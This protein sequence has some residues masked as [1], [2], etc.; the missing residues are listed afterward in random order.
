VR[1]NFRERGPERIRGY[2]GNAGKEA[3]LT[4]DRLPVFHGIFIIG[5]LKGFPQVAYTR[6][7]QT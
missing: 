2:G 6:K 4:I 3:P 7:I 5:A 1:V